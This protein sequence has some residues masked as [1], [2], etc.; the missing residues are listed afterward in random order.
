M[1]GLAG[2]SGVACWPFYLLPQ[3]DRGLFMFWFW[4]LCTET[5]RPGARPGPA[6]TLISL[7]TVCLDRPAIGQDAGS[8]KQLDARSC[9]FHQASQISFRDPC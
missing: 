3:V 4:L 8:V 1:I 9:G 7:P 2:W 6:G 5:A